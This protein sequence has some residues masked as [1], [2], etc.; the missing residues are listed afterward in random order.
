M[1]QA[2]SGLPKS[3]SWT[4]IAG[5]FVHKHSSEL[6]AGAAVTALVVAGRGRI[7]EA[8]ERF[9][10]KLGTSLETEG[11]ES[12]GVTRHSAEFAG[13]DFPQL[14]YD[15]D[16]AKVARAFGNQVRA[17]PT[18]S[19]TGRTIEPRILVVDKESSVSKLYDQANPAIFDVHEMRDGSDIKLGTA[20]LTEGNYLATAQHVAVASDNLFI[21]IAG[22]ARLPVSTAAKDYSA[23]VALLRFTNPVKNLPEALKLGWA[24]SLRK[25]DPVTNLG[26]PSTTNRLVMTE[27]PVTELES[28]RYTT[29]TE[30]SSNFASILTPSVKIR[31]R[32]AGFSGS[33]GSPIFSEGEVVGVHVGTSASDGL[34]RHTAIEHV[35]LLLDQ[36]QKSK[37]PPGGLDVRSIGRVMG[38]GNTFIVDVRKLEISLGDAIDKADY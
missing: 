34:A 21:R 7:A 26:Y 31:S 16:E 3:N 33:S 5:D 12:V 6:L 38:S 17:L 28:N 24:S 13:E 15:I 27:G 10:P 19:V 23:D 30:A 11:S 35:R 25:A 4:E 37:L 36:V 9:L 22:G 8:A 32:A 2:E 18:M 20:F 29:G 14:N 1:E